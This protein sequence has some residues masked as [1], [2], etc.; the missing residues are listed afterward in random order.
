[1]YFCSQ[2][3]FSRN[4]MGKFSKGISILAWVALALLVGGGLFC[5]VYFWREG[6]V[7]SEI[8]A[9]EILQY[10]HDTL[11]Y[12]HFLEE[13]PH[14]EH[15]LEVRTRLLELKAMHAAWKKI[16]HSG[17]RQDFEQFLE[18]YSDMHFSQLCFIKL[19]SIDWVATQEENTPEAYLRYMDTHK[20]SRY[21]AEASIAGDAL[22]LNYVGEEEQQEIKLLLQHFYQALS[23]ND[24]SVLSTCLAPTVGD[25]LG[26]RNTP[27]DSV[28][29]AI[30]KKF[31]SA[32]KKYNFTLGED[33]QFNRMPAANGSINYHVDFCVSRRAKSLEADTA[34]T[35]Y[36][37]TAEINSAKQISGLAMQET[38]QQ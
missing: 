7:R 12:V 2:K 4:E 19:D 18:T 23:D 28:I 10:N 26:Q 32:T 20:D 5:S 29:A 15:C 31:C 21:Y 33:F 6:R 30:G 11:D 13:Y 1:M 25:F 16:E 17:E 35:T 14:S 27:K 36:T 34:S 37:A 8:E 22:A 9:Y 38:S 24:H 3:V